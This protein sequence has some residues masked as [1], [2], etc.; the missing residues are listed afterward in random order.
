[1]GL[2]RELARMN[3]PL[4]I[5]TQWYWKC[6]LHNLLHFLSLRADPHAQY[7]IRA[8]AEAMLE[9]VKRWV[10]I[11]YDAFARHV[12]GGMRLSGPA[13]AIVRRLLAGE[14]VSHA[15]SG[16]SKREWSELMAALGREP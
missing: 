12:M 2:A 3:L 1:P 6:D 7:E 4:N 5:Y 9:T 15:E 10:P 16:L 14:T 8:Y 11:T 13:L